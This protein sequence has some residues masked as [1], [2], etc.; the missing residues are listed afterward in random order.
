MTAEKTKAANAGFKGKPGKRDA[1]LAAAPQHAI[2]E[3]SANLCDKL[4]TVSEAANL[5]DLDLNRPAVINLEPD[6]LGRVF[7]T[8]AKFALGQLKKL[9]R[10]GASGQARAEVALDLVV[11]RQISAVLDGKIPTGMKFYKGNADAIVTENED[12]SKSVHRAMLT[13]GYAIAP[14]Q[15]T[16]ATE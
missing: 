11:V 4:A 2:F 1:S 7:S 8:E 10:G 15:S 6:T 9:F 13:T 12:L 5:K 16:F 3:D 14:N